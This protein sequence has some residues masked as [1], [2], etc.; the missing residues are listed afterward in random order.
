MAKTLMFFQIMFTFIFIFTI[1]I[2]GLLPS[3]I[4]F[5][6]VKFSLYVLFPII[7]IRFFLFD[8][9]EYNFNKKCFNDKDCPKFLCIPPSVPKCLRNHCRC[10]DN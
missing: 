1:V 2:E 3:K 8:I 10:D 7:N 5:F 6:S 4:E 9:A